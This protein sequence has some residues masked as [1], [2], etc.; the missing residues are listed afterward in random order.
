ML[1]RFI[2]FHRRMSLRIGMLLVALGL[3]HLALSGLWVRYFQLTEHMR[4]ISIEFVSG[5]AIG[6]GVVLMVNAFAR[7][8]TQEK[9]ILK[10]EQDRQGS[11]GKT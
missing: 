5:L 10:S 8:E 6:L 1:I 3:A 7:E 11:A 4:S 9:A 2:C